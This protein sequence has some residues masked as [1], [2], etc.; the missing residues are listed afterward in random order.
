MILSLSLSSSSHQSKNKTNNQ[1]PA[2]G[3]SFFSPLSSLYLKQDEDQEPIFLG[4]DFGFVGGCPVP[5]M[6]NLYWIDIVS[7]CIVSSSSDCNLSDHHC[8]SPKFTSC[9]NGP[10]L[11]I[12]DPSS[13]S[14]ET[15]AY[16]GVNATLFA[17]EDDL[18]YWIP[19]FSPLNEVFFP[20]L[21]PFLPFFSIFLLG[22]FFVS[23]S[24]FFFQTQT[25]RSRVV[26]NVMDRESGEQKG[27]T[28][29]SN[30]SL[31]E[32]RPYKTAV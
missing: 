30:I 24:Q 7:D 1:G 23:K 11:Y 20:F 27:S 14:N 28:T 12:E 9:F 2:A 15:S 19:A 6:S 18:V 32:Y 21:F 22:F 10:L 29:F 4:G 13:T 17:F 31:G 16:D 26:V 3:Y 5:Y 25:E 8:H